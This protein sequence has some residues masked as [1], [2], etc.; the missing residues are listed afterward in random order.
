MQPGRKSG[1]TITLPLQPL[2]KTAVESCNHRIKVADFRLPAKPPTSTLLPSIYVYLD[3]DEPSKACKIAASQ[4][5]LPANHLPTLCSQLACIIQ[6][7]PISP[8]AQTTSLEPD[9]IGRSAMS[10]NGL[11]ILNHPAQFLPGPSLLHELV[12]CSPTAERVG[13]SQQA[14]DFL[15]PEGG[16][17][18]NFTYSDLETLSTRFAQRLLLQPGSNIIPVLLPQ[19]PKLYVALL[20]ILKAGA[21]FAPLPLDAPVDRIKFVVG[22]VGAQIVVA[23]RSFKS[24]LSW[25]GCPRVIFVDEED[26]D[27]ASIDKLGTEIRNT[28]TIHPNSPAYVMYTS[29]STGTPKGVIIS[30]SA[31]TQSLLAHEKHIPAY[32]RFLQFASPSFDV[33]VFEVFFTFFRGA[34]LIGCER[35][36]LL[37]DIVGVIN[38]MDVDALELTPT[39]LGELVV[40][41]DRIPK[42]QVVLTIGEMLTRPIV[43]EFGDA[44]LHGMYGPTEAAIHCTLAPNFRKGG[45]VGDVGIPLDTVSAFIVGPVVLGQDITVLPIGWIGELAVGGN[46]LADGYLNRLEQTKEVFI[47]TR[48]GRLYRTGDRARMHPSGTIECFGRN[49]TGQVKLRGQRIELGEV[50]EA[51][52]KIQGVKGAVAS[53]ISGSLVAFIGCESHVTDTVVREAVKKW[54]PGYMVPNTVITMTEIPKLSSGKADR[55]RLEKEYTE[56]RTQG[57]AHKTDDV[58]SKMEKTIAAAVMDI[59]TG[60][61]VSR[62]SSF[63]ASGLDSLLAIRLCSK[64]RESGLVTEV[65][66]I[67]RTDCIKELACFI[68]SHP[69]DKPSTDT[70]IQTEQR[71]Q[72]VRTA[73]RSRILELSCLDIEDVEDIIPCTPLQDTMLSETMRDSSVYC[74]WYLLEIPSSYSD[75]SIELAFRKLILRNEI[76]R[77]GFLHLGQVLGTFAQI[78]W[79]SPREGQFATAE[80]V[81]KLQRFSVED[82]INPPFKAFL[83]R[84]ETSVKLSIH[85]HHALYDG[86]SWD[87]ILRDLNRFLM[88][89]QNGFVSK[90]PQFREVV[91]Y[92]LH[93]DE[94]RLNRSTAFWKEALADAPNS[95]LPNFYGYSG[96]E[97]STSTEKMQLQVSRIDLERSARELGISPQVILQTSWAYLLSTYLQSSDVLFGTVISGRT[98]PLPGIEEVIG[99]CIST[100]P[101]RVRLGDKTKSCAELMRDVHEFNRSL[102]IYGDLDLRQIKKYCGV[103]SGAFD[104]LLIWQ[105][106]TLERE[107][108]AVCPIKQVDGLDRL[109]V[110][111]F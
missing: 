23:D 71:F 58:M 10:N 41:R 82:M 24:K 19:S 62:E 74:N 78:V 45:S 69:G 103:G 57:A 68:N 8:L 16:V 60:I 97:Q 22:D 42:V 64:L 109:E 91:R 55:K 84:Q 52:R 107:D 104:T 6:S 48:Y 98:I 59:L 39:V 26:I 1:C 92:N 51:I 110:R 50:E 81:D 54:L 102:L 43:D 63:V 53:V 56:Q 29:G 105:Q 67:L 66:D 108:E 4:Q 75:H 72:D 99:P 12:L 30:H 34:T 2:V 89:G 47:D 70:S 95:K 76:L 11:S 5:L 106:T 88:K 46:Q 87:H 40:T 18:Q 27:I 37:S 32:H 79:D 33:F 38:K 28:T 7:K 15:P 25:D 93:K 80:T 9:D 94:T 21:A 13:Y 17:R 36:R 61:E 96:V 49:S 65:A 85:I 44:I 83:I 3:P 14:L 86:W 100:L 31:A 20:G 90:R 111:E 77:T 35:S 73:G 101:L